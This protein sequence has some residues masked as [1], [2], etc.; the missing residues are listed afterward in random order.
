MGIKI[1]KIKLCIQ[2]HWWWALAI[3]PLGLYILAGAF[4]ID[5]F[6]GAK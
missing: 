3:I 2:E 4:G 6:G 5:P 1:T